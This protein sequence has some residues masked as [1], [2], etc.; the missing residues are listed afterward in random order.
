MYSIH[1]SS[2]IKKGP[3][4]LGPNKLIIEDKRGDY[5]SGD[6]DQYVVTIN[7]RPPMPGR[8]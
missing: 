4:H 1:P 2:E 3:S 7:I 5:A 6:G 8:W